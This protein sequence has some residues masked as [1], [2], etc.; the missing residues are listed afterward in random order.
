MAIVNP[1]PLLQIPKAFLADKEVKAFIEQQNTIIFQ[2]YN[3]T[4]GNTDFIEENEAKVTNSSSRINK[5]TANINTLALKEF[6]ILTTT[7]DL[8]TKEYQIIICKNTLPISITLDSQ[9]VKDDEVHIK[10]RGD[11]VTVVGFIDGLND[12]IINVVNW[13]EHYVFDGTDWSVI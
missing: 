13:S 6:E 9:A 7:E 11:Q 1:P 12:R 5:N 2:L 10:R 4:G 8:T 3:R